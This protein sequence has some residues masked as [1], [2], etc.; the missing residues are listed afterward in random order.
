MFNKDQPLLTHINSTHAGLN[1]Q[2]WT[3]GGC[4]ITDLMLDFRPKG[5]WAWQ[6]LKANSTTQLFLSELREATWYE[7]K[8]KACNSAGCGNQSSQFA[9]T[10]YDG[11]KCVC[12][13]SFR[14]V[15]SYT[16]SHFSAGTIPPIKSARGEGDDVKKLFS[17]GSPVIL[18]TLGVALLFIIRKKRKEK[19]LKRLRG[20]GSPPATDFN[21]SAPVMAT[22]DTFNVKQTQLPQNC[23]R[24]ARVST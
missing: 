7:L 11:S 22:T 1:L 24:L 12:R 2:G 17:I 5:T 18:V 14:L 16:D 20:E 15:S 13:T 3:S 19:R 23:C 10:D 9:T 6:S 21:H 8:M 4:P